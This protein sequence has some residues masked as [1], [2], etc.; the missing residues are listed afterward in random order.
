MGNDL[1]ERGWR[2][3]SKIQIVRCPAGDG[4]FVAC[5]FAYFSHSRNDANYFDVVSTPQIISSP[6]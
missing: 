6:L 2:S 3:S 1:G 5:L 4:F